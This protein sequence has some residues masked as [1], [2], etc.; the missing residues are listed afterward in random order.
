MSTSSSE[1]RFDQ[2]PAKTFTIDLGSLWSPRKVP[3][4]AEFK[5][6]YKY[7]G[8]A[9]SRNQDIANEWEMKDP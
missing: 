6:P 8:D 5:D 2:K 4:E 9:Y 1:K 3:H 7:N